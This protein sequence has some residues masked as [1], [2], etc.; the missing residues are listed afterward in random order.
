MSLWNV[1]Y[2]GLGYDAC[3]PNKTCCDGFFG[4]IGVDFVSTMR[5]LKTLVMA[6]L[7]IVPV[8]VLKI[9]FMSVADIVS[10]RDILAGRETIL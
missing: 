6:V 5:V 1:D 9:C 8:R 4:G 3:V 10:Y 7:K 2:L